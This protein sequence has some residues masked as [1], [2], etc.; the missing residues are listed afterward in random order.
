[1]STTEEKQQQTTPRHLQSSP[2][3]DNDNDI[4]YDEDI[5]C[6]EEDCQKQGHPCVPEQG[7]QQNQKDDGQRAQQQPIPEKQSDNQS[8]QLQGGQGDQKNQPDE[9]QKAQ[10]QTS[11]QKGNQQQNQQGRQKRQRNRKQ[12]QQRLTPQ[13]ARSN[14]SGQQNQQGQQGDQQ[15]QK[16]QGQRA[17][18][19]PNNN[20]QQQQQQQGSRANQQSK[21]RGLGFNEGIQ[22][23]FGR[24][25]GESVSTYTEKMPCS[26]K[27]LFEHIPLEAMMIENWVR[28]RLV[29]V[30][31]K[32]PLDKALQRL[33][34]HK[35]TSLPIINE[36]SGNIKGIL[37][38]LDVVNYLCSVL[39]KEDLA[40]ARWDF[41][42]QTTGQLLDM[43]QKKAFV[44]SNKATMYD[45]LLQ[46]AKGVPRLMVFDGDCTLHQQEKEEQAILGLFT[47]SDIVRFLA[48]N[49]YW[50]ALSPSSQKTLKELGILKNSSEQVISVDQS[51]PAYQAFKK[52]S[53][54]N[55]TGIVV[56]DAQGRIVANLSAANIRG[57]SR[58]NFQLLRRPLFE[59]L[60]R[61]RRR[62][63]WTMPICIRESDTL[64]KCILQ[65][66]STKVHQMY[67][68][69]D[70]GKATNVVTLTDV[71]GHFVMQG[72]NA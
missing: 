28:K 42:L 8:Q 71:L 34:R 56:N 6:L 29:L 39:D 10:Q 61:D 51:I 1:M 43:S 60:Q 58:R 4:Y 27:E 37:D 25:R 16:D 36:E 18:Q 55:S 62:G 46:L 57:I 47:Q 59:F 35:I 68:C 38:S 67:V 32:Q 11:Q 33:N 14:Q 50:L 13:N 72:N 20:Q 3:S 7:D 23:P 31:D 44:I 17:Q 66:G 40:P 45:G 30:G 26:V 5:E 49:P 54:T 52:I 64:E 70:N 15:N 12:R 48:S 53:D 41:N 24:F 63:W 21:G 9:G 65:F 69:D 19:S 22:G 2:R